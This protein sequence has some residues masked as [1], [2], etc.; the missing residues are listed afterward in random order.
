MTFTSHIP[1]DG[2]KL[3]IYAKLGT[4]FIFKICSI[5]LLPSMSLKLV[6]SRFL[7]I[8]RV[9]LIESYLEIVIHYNVFHK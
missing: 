8:K 2:D 1:F 9:I 7:L 4:L 5:T 6:I 3:Y